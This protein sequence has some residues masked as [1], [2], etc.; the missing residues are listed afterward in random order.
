M[1][2]GGINHAPNGLAAEH[3]FCGGAEIQLPAIGPPTLRAMAGIGPT[4]HFCS[5]FTVERLG[6]F[7]F[8]SF[9]EVELNHINL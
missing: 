8:I 3:I 6:P 4:W 9:L 7:R 2:M 1:L 5:G